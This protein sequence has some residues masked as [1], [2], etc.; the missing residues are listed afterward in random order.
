MSALLDDISRITASTISRREAFKLVGG[1]VGGT[2]LAYLGVGRASRGL[3]APAGGAQPVQHG[4]IKVCGHGKSLC[5]DGKTCCSTNET[6][7]N[8]KCCPSGQ[9]CTT[10]GHCC[11]TSQVC[12]DTCCG[13]SAHC[14][15]GICCSANQA[16][17]GVNKPMCCAPGRYCCSGK[18]LGKTP[19]GNL[20]C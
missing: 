10:D 20:P 11:R 1:A 8:G 15:N 3:G 19:S 2:L 18:C 13:R 7:C 12:G 5:P 17:C 6:C 9:T 4:I 16:C 14:C